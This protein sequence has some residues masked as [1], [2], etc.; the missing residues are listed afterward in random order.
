VGCGRGLHSDS[1]RGTLVPP[2]SS[3]G[4]FRH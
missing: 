4:R 3:Q 1:E 2:E